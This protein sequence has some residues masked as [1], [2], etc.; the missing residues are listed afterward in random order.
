MTIH[1]TQT[2]QTAAIAVEDFHCPGSNG[3]GSIEIVSAT[4]LCIV[5]T[6]RRLPALFAP[7]RAL[8][9]PARRLLPIRVTFGPCCEPGDRLESPS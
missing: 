3:D 8:A 7:F 6:R 5:C 2:F 9:A 4:Q 1:G